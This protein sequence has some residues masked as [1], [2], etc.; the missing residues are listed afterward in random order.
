MAIVKFV[1]LMGQI[2]PVKSPLVYVLTGFDKSR[3][4]P[5]HEDILLLGSNDIR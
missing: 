5:E 2:T 4:F 3:I 1:L